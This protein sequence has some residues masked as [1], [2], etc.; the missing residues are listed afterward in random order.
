MMMIKIETKI[1]VMVGTLASKLS[2]E[3]MKKKEKKRKE[4]KKGTCLDENDCLKKLGL[5]EFFRRKQI[6]EKY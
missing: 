2:L 6:L 5:S 4:K 1:A 3:W